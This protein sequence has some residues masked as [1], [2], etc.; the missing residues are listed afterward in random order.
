M[1]EV[2]KVKTGYLALI[3]TTILISACA[4]ILGQPNSEAR[5]TTTSEELLHVLFI[6]SSHITVNNLHKVFEWLTESSGREVDA[7]MAA[8]PGVMLRDHLNDPDTLE[9]LSSR[10]WDFVVLQEDMYV[11]GNE[12]DRAEQSYPA[13]RAL[14]EL[15]HAAGATTVFFVTWGDPWPLR[16]GNLDEYLEAQAQIAAGYQTI[17][18]ELGA[19]IAP[20]GSAVEEVLRQMPGTYLWIED[21]IYG[22]ANLQGTYLAACV[23]Y[24]VIY[25]ESPE[26][27]TFIIQPEDTALALQSIAAE[28]VAEGKP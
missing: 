14:N 6:G 1:L 17:G 7:R 11:I 3:I 19:L 9:I 28:V 20:V 5:I 16:E 22:H 2:H 15:I 23:L 13:I 18:E 4:P 10:V 27:L 24:A 25:D 8:T 26:G 21:D 12:Q